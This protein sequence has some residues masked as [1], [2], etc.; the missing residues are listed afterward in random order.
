MV[1][2]SIAPRFTQ[3]IHLTGEGLRNELVTTIGW[4][5]MQNSAGIPRGTQEWT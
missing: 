5:T 3:K 1:R 2:S 4:L